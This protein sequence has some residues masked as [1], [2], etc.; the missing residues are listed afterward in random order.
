MQGKTRVILA[1]SKDDAV[2]SDQVFEWNVKD[3]S[4]PNKRA[5][6]SIGAR[7]MCSKIT[8][9]A[10]CGHPVVLAPLVLYDQ[11]RLAPAE[12]QMA[13]ELDL[14]VLL[15]RMKPEMQPGIF[16]FC[17]ISEE[18]EILATVR[19]LLT[20]REREGTTVIVRQEEAE[21]MGLAYRFASRLIT[22]TVH[23]SLEAVGF[24]AAI[25]A[26]LAEAGISVNAVSAFYHDHLFVP[27]DR[28]DEALT[29]L[30]EM[31]RK[32]PTH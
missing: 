29:R 27:Q 30:Q 3:A 9:R 8:R 6:R 11:K 24:L 14:Q 4:R 13:S 19:P 20:F 28:A 1:P 32:L 18:I 5:D 26:R 10:S 21:R 22:M 15:S 2:S 16:V 17:T 25:T 12:L 7:C 31:M 23:S